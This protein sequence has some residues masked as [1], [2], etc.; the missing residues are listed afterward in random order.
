MLQERIEILVSSMED[1]EAHR[2]FREN[3]EK[4]YFDLINEIRGHLYRTVNIVPRR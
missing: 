1:E 3:F 2:R 4:T